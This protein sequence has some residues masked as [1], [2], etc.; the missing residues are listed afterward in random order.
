MESS[1][2]LLK[3]NIDFSLTERSASSMNLE[4]VV[5]KTGVLLLLCIAAGA[6]S[7]MQ[8]QLQPVFIIVGLIGG[9]IACLVG[10]F[11]PTTAPIAAPIYAIFE[12]LCLGA[13][14]Y[15]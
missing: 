5:N 9:L 11:K 1:N 6:F 4:G 14:S 12:G 10:I 13:I 8:P 7:W 3:R 15:F 2:P